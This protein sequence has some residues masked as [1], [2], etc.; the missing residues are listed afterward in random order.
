MIPD[1]AQAAA[2]TFLHDMLCVSLAGA[3]ASCAE[4]IVSTA[5]GWGAGADRGSCLLLGRT[6]RM[7]AA[8]AAFVNAFQI[9][10]QEY[11]CV[12][13]PAVV[14]PLA[15][16][17][18]VPLAELGRGRGRPRS[19][20][21][22]LHTVE[23]AGQVDVDRRL[24]VVGLDLQQR[25]HDVADAGTVDPDVE[26]TMRGDRVIGERLRLLARTQVAGMRRD[27]TPA[28]RIAS[29]TSVMVVLV[30]IIAAGVA[31]STGGR[32]RR[33]RPPPRRPPGGWRS[34]PPGPPGAMIR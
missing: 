33:S 31:A 19:P 4:Q 5:V 29:A 18:A 15:T 26:A 6:I 14:H 1:D 3:R 9:H 2:A 34:L 24:P 30:P 12:H 13:E 22:R 28:A 17:V 10:T 7:P 25:L 23:R 16:I 32:Y 27:D 8:D 21:R 20:G 11:D